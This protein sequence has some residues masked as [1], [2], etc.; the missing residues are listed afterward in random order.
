MAAMAKR[1]FT[2][3]ALILMGSKSFSKAISDSP[4]AIDDL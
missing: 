1:F 2:S 3:I 4:L